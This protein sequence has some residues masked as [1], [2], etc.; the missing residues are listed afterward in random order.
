MA[1]R[2]EIDDIP[3]SQLKVIRDL[4][5]SGAT[6]I[7]VGGFLG[8]AAAGLNDAMS[9]PDSR[10]WLSLPS[11]IS[12]QRLVLPAGYRNLTLRARSAKGK[13]LHS[14]KVKLPASG[15]CIVY[16]RNTNEKLVAH[17]S[18]GKWE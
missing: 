14:V 4:V 1:L 6:R 17:V 15:P 8:E 11:T 16:G 5:R 3:I 10:S 12:V 13:V 2:H 9:M 7:L 18:K